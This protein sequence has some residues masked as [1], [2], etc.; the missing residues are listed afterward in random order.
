MNNE[1]LEISK[2]AHFVVGYDRMLSENT[3]LKI[4]GYYQHLY[5]IPVE[6]DSTSAFSL[7]NVVE[8][9]TVLDLVNQGTGRNYGVE[10][11][12]ERYLNRGFYYLGTVSLYRS[13]YTA[14]DGVERS[15]LFDGNYVANFL[16]GKE[17]DY[18]KPGK[19]RTFFVNGKLAFI[20]G[21]RYTPIDL[22][23]SRALGT[24]VDGPATL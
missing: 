10:V 16:A 22:E 18:G 21:A 17:F 24:A 23:A 14:L 4:E 1:D 6:N 15:S 12:L 11:T 13:L 8:G 7:S 2:S 3:H 19:E 5:D 20:G 9:Y